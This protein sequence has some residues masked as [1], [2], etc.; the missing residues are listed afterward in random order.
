MT[1]ELLRSRH[2]WEMTEPSYRRKLPHWRQDQATYFVTW[3]LAWGQRE[4]DA[5][6]RDLVLAAMKKFDGQ[7]YELAAYAVMDDHVHALV[8]PLATYELKRILHSWKSFAARQL[9]RGKRRFGRVWQDEYLHRIIRDDKLTRS[10]CKSATTSSPIHGS[11]ARARRLPL[12]MAFRAVTDLYVS[13]SIS[14]AAD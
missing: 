3:R 1:R 12:G 13:V 10:S 11:V 8:T 5:S 14:S 9:Q 2:R 7:R 6:E 4:L